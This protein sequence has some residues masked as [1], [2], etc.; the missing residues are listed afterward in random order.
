MSR[1]GGLR[2]LC[3]LIAGPT[4]WAAAFAAAYGMHGVGCALGWP[5]MMLGPVSLQRA[6]IALVCVIGVLACL[7]LLARVRARL[8]PDATIPRWGLWIGAGA[9]AFTLAPALLASTC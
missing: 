2:W 5:A 8:G 1:D 6:V 4:I 7:A 3:W 9:T